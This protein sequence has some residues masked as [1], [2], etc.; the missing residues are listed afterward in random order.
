M[1][2]RAAALGTITGIAAGIGVHLLLAGRTVNSAVGE[3]GPGLSSPVSGAQQPGSRLEGTKPRDLVP[4]GETS[5]AQVAQG[6]REAQA[7]QPQPSPTSHALAR[8][9]EASRQPLGAGAGDAWRV[10]FEELHARD[11]ALASVV[12]VRQ[13]EVFGSDGIRA[14][15]QEYLRRSGKRSFAFQTDLALETVVKESSLRL[16][17]F[18]PEAAEGSP[19][20]GDAQFRACFQKAVAASRLACPGCKD[21]TITV[22]WGIVTAFSLDAEPEL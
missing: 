20:L 8:P 21:G 11:P 14:C 7:G 4:S 2:V 22:P 1:N 12:R 9:T 18:L 5:T 10:A 6:R 3:H 13:G 16:D 17:T 15:G 19:E